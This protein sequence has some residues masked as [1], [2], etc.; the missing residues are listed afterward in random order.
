MHIYLSEEQ[1]VIYLSLSLFNIL[2]KH[3]ETERSHVYDK[4]LNKIMLNMCFIKHACDHQIKER[5]PVELLLPVF[6]I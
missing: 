5:L 2:K 4:C 3:T 1:V 6:T